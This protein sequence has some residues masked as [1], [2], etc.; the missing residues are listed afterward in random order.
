MIA[1]SEQ[2]TLWS[3]QP[4]EVWLQLQREGQ[5]AANPVLGGMWETENCRHAYEWIRVQMRKR[6]PAHAYS[7]GWPWWAWTT[8]P[9]LRHHRNIWRIGQRG[10]R[11]ELSL[12][13]ERALFSRFGAW[14]AVLNQYHYSCDDDAYEGF[15]H[16]LEAK[17]TEMGAG[18]ASCLEGWI[19]ARYREDPAAACPLIR[20]FADEIQASWECILDLDKMND[21]E[22]HR[23]W[24]NQ[25]CFE[26]LRMDDVRGVTEF[27]GAYRKKTGTA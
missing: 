20:Q 16:R 9:D 2:V 19:M 25:A 5:L 23:D 6:L 15:Q 27:V 26:W 13:T 24:P 7:G 10:V 11:M 3:M 1:G 12:P 8:K 18:G 4:I 22:Y 17:A 21:S 14:D